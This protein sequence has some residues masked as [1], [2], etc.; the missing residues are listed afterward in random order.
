MYINE[1]RDNSLAFDM[2]NVAPML[3]EHFR[4]YI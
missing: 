4:I 3:F 2:H 1:W